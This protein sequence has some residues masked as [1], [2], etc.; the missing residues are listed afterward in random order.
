VQ[1]AGLSPYGPRPNASGDPSIARFD[2]SHVQFS[3]FFNSEFKFLL[4]HESNFYVI[5]F[6][7]G[8]NTHDVMGRVPRS[9]A[10]FDVTATAAS[11]WI[12]AATTSSRQPGIQARAPALLSHLQAR[13]TGRHRGHLQ[14]EGKPRHGE[15]LRGRH[16]CRN[17]LLLRH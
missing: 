15:C 2:G 12:L 4:M 11:S 6:L 5:G 7:Y 13:D 9:R 16:R 17:N 1:S 3:S 10:D 8:S 14:L